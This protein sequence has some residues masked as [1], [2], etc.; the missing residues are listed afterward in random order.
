MNDKT[1]SI[2]EHLEALRKVLIISIVSLIP[3]SFAGWYLREQVMAILVEPVK[4]A[5]Q[6]LVYLGPTE[7]F[8]VEMKIAVIA[9]FVLASPIIFWQ[10]WGFILPALKTHEKRYL[11][12]VVPLSILLFAVG[13]F[14]G[15]S[16]VFKYGIEFLLGFATDELTPMLSLSQY[17]SFTF[18][19]LFPFGLMFELP[20]GMF[21]MAKIGIINHSFLS[22]NRKFA[23][24]IIFIIAAVVTPTT[25][26][27]SMTI[28]AIPMYILYEISILIIRLV[29][30]RAGYEAVEAAAVA[31][32]AETVTDDTIDNSLSADADKDE[33]EDI[34][35][36]I[37]DRG[38]PNR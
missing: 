34:Y 11:I 21:F 15:Y 9:G 22:K 17:I 16:T 7:A 8:M 19:F 32:E 14:F 27:L 25:D 24:L 35:K 33:L 2:L 3:A 20:L 29:Q 13:V 26:M 4:A 18:W 23:L 6:K 28:M 37:T 36:N 1:M 12:L 10:V 38:K 5:H 30:P 31:L